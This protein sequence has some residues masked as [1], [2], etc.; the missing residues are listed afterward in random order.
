MKVR[1]VMCNSLEQAVNLHRLCPLSNNG[2]QVE[3]KLVLCKMTTAAENFQ[4]DENV[5]ELQYIWVNNVKSTEPTRV[6]GLLPFKSRALRST[7]I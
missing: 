2:Y 5:S 1:R 7:T 3:L 6:S 4:G